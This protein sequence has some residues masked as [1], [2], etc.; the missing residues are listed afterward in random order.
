M[1]LDVF[2]GHC[3]L[4]SLCCMQDACLSLSHSPSPLFVHSCIHSVSLSLMLI[5]FHSN[6]LYTTRPTNYTSIG[7]L[8]PLLTDLYLLYYLPHSL[9][10]CCIANDSITPMHH[11]HS[12]SIYPLHYNIL[13]SIECS[14]FVRLAVCSSV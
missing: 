6:T 1:L 10:F 9:S 2:T 11:T 3:T 14:L 13:Y 5:L 8:S 7:F 12:L 4:H